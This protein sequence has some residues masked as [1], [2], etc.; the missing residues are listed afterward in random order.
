MST[1][2]EQRYPLEILQQKSKEEL[3]EIIGNMEEEVAMLDF[4]IA[5]YEAMQESIGKAIQDGLTEHLKNTVLNG[6][7]T[8]EA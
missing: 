1:S 4:L 2:K 3:I 7:E 6:T 5:E 8:G